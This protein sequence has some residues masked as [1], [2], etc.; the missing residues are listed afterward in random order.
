MAR[1]FAEAHIDLEVY[2]GPDTTL[3]CSPW[4]R[5]RGRAGAAKVE[6]IGVNR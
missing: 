5:D 2:A 3:F 6:L 4:A 1:R